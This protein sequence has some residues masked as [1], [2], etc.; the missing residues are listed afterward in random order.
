MSCFAV[1]FMHHLLERLLKK[2]GIKDFDALDGAKLTDGSLS[3]K[4]T[5]ETYENILS[6]DS[7]TLEDVKHFC[8]SQIEII[9][10]KWRDLNIRKE[11][12]AEWIPYISVYK[13]LLSAIDSPKAA[14]ENLEKYLNSLLA[15]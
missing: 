1:F 4:Q 7:L 8:A 15:E 10:A 6:K 11:V 13:A 5:F 14:R 12:K 2:R 3:E 9:E